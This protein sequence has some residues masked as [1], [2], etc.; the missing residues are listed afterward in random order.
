MRKGLFLAAFG[1]AAAA[2]SQKADTSAAPHAAT[3]APPAATAQAATEQTPVGEPDVKSDSAVAGDVIEGPAA[4]KW[5]I[6]TTMAGAPV[7][8]PP[9]E[10]CYTKK[11]FAEMQTSRQAP[12]VEC[13]EQSYKRQGGKVV[14]H[15]VCTVNGRKMTTD[16]TVTGD[17]NTAYTM[18]MTTAIDPPPAPGMSE[19]KMTLRAERLGDCDS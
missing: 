18:D 6:T 2:C 13:S 15:S 8:I 19:Q 5:R 17:L 3:P 9:I 14:G 12:G 11:T 7:A 16:M 1:L 4:G 10:T